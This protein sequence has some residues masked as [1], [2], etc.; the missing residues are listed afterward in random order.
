[1]SGLMSGP[2]K[3]QNMPGPLHFRIAT[4]TVGHMDTLLRIIGVRFNRDRSMPLST[5]ILLGC[6]VIL[7]QFLDFVSTFSGVTMG[8]AQEAN[9]LMVRAM[10]AY[11]WAG[12]IGIKV[13]ATVLM[14]LL[15]WRRFGASVAFTLI[16]FGIAGWNTYV[17]L[18]GL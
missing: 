12:F 6:F 13:I 18:T 8:A 5:A 16:Y 17:G 9:P 7:S 1:M 14:L 11:G 2:V 10:D 15:T 3:Q 4:L